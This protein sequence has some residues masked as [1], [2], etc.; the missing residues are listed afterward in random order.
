MFTTVSTAWPGKC[1]QRAQSSAFT[2]HFS[3]AD[4]FVYHDLQQQ[5]H[6]AGGL[7]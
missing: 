5:S 6:S 7:S 1:A 3:G 2:M 4:F